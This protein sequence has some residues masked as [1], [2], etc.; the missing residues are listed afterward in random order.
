MTDDTAPVLVGIDG[1]DHSIR[2]L[3]WAVA[4]ARAVGA[5]LSAV[6]VI[7]E[8]LAASE[9]ADEVEE[10][11]VAEA[12][13]ILEADGALTY[14][15]N[16]HPGKPVEQ[17]VRASEGARAVVMGSQGH[18]T[19]ADL[20]VG[21][22]SQ[23]VARHAACPVVV[24]R[25]QERP[26]ADHI[27]VGTDG[28][29]ES[30]PALDWA[31]AYAAATGVE[32]SVV[33]GFRTSASSPATLSGYIPTNVGEEIAAGEALLAEVVAPYA[34]RYPGVVVRQDAVPVPASVALADASQTAALVVVG[35]RGRGA[36]EGM[37][38]GSVSQRL[39]HHARCSVAVV[40]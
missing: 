24:V 38:L 26:D 25:E 36:F 17:L 5:P 10:S 9:A 28:S 3:H 39:L 15:V 30:G 40:R 29:E 18:G 21:S 23:H 14:D 11:L 32:L 6:G 37:L 12:R 33:Y 35:S 8:D 2:A 16:V 22:V 1:S 20:V 19:I 7:P 27:V 34:A 13:G 4:Y 31:F